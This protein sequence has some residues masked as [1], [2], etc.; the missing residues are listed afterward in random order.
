MIPP[1]NVIEKQVH[2]DREPTKVTQR[3]REKEGNAMNAEE[4]QTECLLQ[5]LSIENDAVHKPNDEDEGLK[6]HYQLMHK[7]LQTH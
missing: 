4:D 5:K 3:P 2:F 1:S 7:L 6:H